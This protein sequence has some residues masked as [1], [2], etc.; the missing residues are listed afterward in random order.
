MKKLIV[1]LLTAIATTVASGSLVSC[2][3]RRHADV[4]DSAVEIAQMN[5]YMNPTFDNVSDFV[6]YATDRASSATFVAIVSKLDRVTITTIASTALKKNNGNKVD[7]RSWLDEYNLH[8]DIYT[9]MDR[10]SREQKVANATV[11]TV[12]SDTVEYSSLQTANK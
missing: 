6:D 5:A 4:K 7:W 11:R 9:E 12:P 2:K 1:L 8:R 3:D 10:A